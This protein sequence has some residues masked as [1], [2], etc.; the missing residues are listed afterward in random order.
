MSLAAA[1]DASGALPQDNWWLEAPGVFPENSTTRDGP[2]Y[3]LLA[4]SRITLEAIRGLIWAGNAMGLYH[5]PANL[6]IKDG[7]LST[8]LQ[9]DTPVVEFT[10]KGQIQLNI[11]SGRCHSEPTPAASVPPRFANSGNERTPFCQLRQRAYPVLPLNRNGSAH[12]QWNPA[13]FYSRFSI[14]IWSFL[15]YNS[16]LYFNLVFCCTSPRDSST[17]S[18]HNDI[19]N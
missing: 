9:W 2:A 5:Y 18:C 12:T 15:H 10:D 7:N 14:C 4:G 8:L 17:C 13:L 1:A 11:T 6:T 19:Q 16:S 3:K